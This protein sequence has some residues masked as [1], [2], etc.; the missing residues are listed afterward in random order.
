MS[1]TKASFRRTKR[2]AIF[3]YDFSMI[4][5]EGL[6]F[7]LSF[8]M[9]FANPALSVISFVLGSLLLIINYFILSNLYK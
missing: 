6:L 9:M 4:F 1:G 8:W 2:T 5:I 3:F 7:S